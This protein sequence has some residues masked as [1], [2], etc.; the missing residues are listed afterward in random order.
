MNSQLVSTRP[1]AEPTADEKRVELFAAAGSRIPIQKFV[2]F[3][4]IALVNIKQEIRR[5]LKQISLKTM[6]SIVITMV[7]NIIEDPKMMKFRKLRRNNSRLLKLS[8][9][10]IT[11]V[12]N[13]LLT[14]GFV[15]RDEDYEQIY[16]FLDDP[17]SKNWELL[18]LGRDLVL[19]RIAA[20]IKL[21]QE[22]LDEI[23]KHLQRKKEH[24]ELVGKIKWDMVGRVNGKRSA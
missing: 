24:E 12:T 14:I 9:G 22:R 20:L 13:F 15:A 23:G 16:I 5:I 21:E 4:E 8:T 17:D 2:H 10:E 11:L 18:A 1:P 19:E 6:E 3:T 7:E